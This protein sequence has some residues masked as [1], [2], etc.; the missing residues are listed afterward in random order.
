LPVPFKVP[1]TSTYAQIIIFSRPPKKPPENNSSFIPYHVFLLFA[2]PLPY[3]NGHPTTQPFFS[4]FFRGGQNKPHAK[5]YSS[6]KIYPFIALWPLFGPLKSGG[7][8]RV[9]NELSDLVRRYLK[10]STI[11]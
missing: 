4:K 7:K 2:V 10:L 8:Q 5:A 9:E 3:M 11:I 6:L 1:D